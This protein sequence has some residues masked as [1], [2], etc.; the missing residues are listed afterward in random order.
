MR[1]AKGVVKKVNDKT[2]VRGLVHD[3]FERQN[4]PATAQSLTDA[5]GSCAS[6]TVVQKALEELHQSG[7]LLVKD[8]KKVRFYFLRPHATDVTTTQNDDT[9]NKDEHRGTTDV[10]AAATTTTTVDEEVR[11][12]S[13]DDDDE[14][15]EG[16]EHAAELVATT[17]MQPPSESHV[18]PD[19][20]E[21]D[22]D[23]YAKMAQD[24][25][26]LENDVAEKRALL[27]RLRAVPTLAQRRAEL[28]AL[29]KEVALL[30]R[31]VAGLEELEAAAARGEARGVQHV[32]R[33]QRLIRRY[34]ASR[35]AWR[36]RKDYTYRFIDAVLG[37]TC[38]IRDIAERT[39]MV[40]DE[41]Q[42]VSLTASAVS[43]PSCLLRLPA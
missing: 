43:L 13:G 5:L 27:A 6:K 29:E 39:G 38:T 30:H 31:R 21:A 22:D 12:A 4:R 14:D 17:S 9:P 41:T 19:H 37:D 2:T 34:Q 32:Q 11:D 8:L 33:M 35:Q 25:V 26:A 23:D 40:T 1:S 28:D 24:I 36:E 42:N 15:E 7:I 3:W 18:T 20:K 16:G 10:A